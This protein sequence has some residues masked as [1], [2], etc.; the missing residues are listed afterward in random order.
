MEIGVCRVYTGMQLSLS[1]SVHRCMQKE[2]GVGGHTWKG[3]HTWRE[4][5][6]VDAKQVH[7]H[8]ERPEERRE[9]EG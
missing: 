9:E 6:T 7:G 1:G 8:L 3:G 2:H 4:A 5:A